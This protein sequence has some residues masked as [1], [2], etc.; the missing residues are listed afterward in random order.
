MVG[1]RQTLFAMRVRKCNFHCPW[2]LRGSVEVYL[3][4]RHLIS[5]SP[6]LCRLLWTLNLLSSNCDTLLDFLFRHLGWVGE[7]K[8]WGRKRQ[9]KKW[10]ATVT[11][12]I[13][14]DNIYDLTT[15]LMTLGCSPSKT[16]RL[17][18]LSPLEALKG[19]RF[20]LSALFY[21]ERGVN[22]QHVL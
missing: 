18:Y 22:K 13:C 19:Q 7:A 21:G 3:L 4:C 10:N 8:R 12:T 9:A 16:A 15:V 14:F 5:R 20:L 11:K 17:W 1:G 6:G 2:Y